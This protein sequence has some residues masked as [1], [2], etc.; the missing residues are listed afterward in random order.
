MT[1]QMYH[2]DTKSKIKTKKEIKF[3]HDCTQ[4]A[5]VDLQMSPHCMDSTQLDLITFTIEKNKTKLMALVL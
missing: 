1:G 4:G 3:H 5:F 2:H